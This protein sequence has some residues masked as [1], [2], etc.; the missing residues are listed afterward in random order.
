MWCISLVSLLH[1][2]A[3]LLAETGTDYKF[4]CAD[5][6]QSNNTQVD[7]ANIL[8][9][10]DLLYR[11]AL[12]TGVRVLCLRSTRNGNATIWLAPMQAPSLQHV[13]RLAIRRILPTE[14]ISALKMPVRLKRFLRYEVHW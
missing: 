4:S 3:C 9:V 11:Q 13:C 1:R 5:F 7:N 10:A 14:G 8:E 12:N 2:N 6:C